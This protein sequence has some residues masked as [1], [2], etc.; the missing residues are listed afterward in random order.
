MVSISF[1]FDRIPN[2][3]TILCLDLTSFSFRYMN[4]THRWCWSCTESNHCC[5]TV[6]FFS[7]KRWSQLTT[8]HEGY[9][10][11]H[12]RGR[13]INMLLNM[14]CSKFLVPFWCNF[15]RKLKMV[16]SHSTNTLHCIICVTVK[17]AGY[18]CVGYC[19]LRPFW[20]QDGYL[21]SLP[22]WENF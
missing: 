16:L 3:L 21:L 13:N 20:R 7:Y 1:L 19:P 6:F 14:T 2:I 12:G 4:Y 9:E 18:S 8:V 22:Y 11:A 15:N 10:L 5:G 17:S